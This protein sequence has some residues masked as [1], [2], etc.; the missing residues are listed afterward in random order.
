M[1]DAP[2]RRTARH[3]KPLRSGVG[4]WVS[5][6]RDPA[7]DAKEIYIGRIPPEDDLAEAFWRKEVSHFLIVIAGVIRDTLHTADATAFRAINSHGRSAH[8]RWSTTINKWV[9]DRPCR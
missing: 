8:F 3:K 1:P 7:S 9:G 2:S 6:S 5:M 4:I